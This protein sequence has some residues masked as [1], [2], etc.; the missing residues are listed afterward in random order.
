MNRVF[1]PLLDKGVLITL[2]DILVYNK[3][4]EQHKHLLQ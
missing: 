1:F 3:T 4:I 2:D